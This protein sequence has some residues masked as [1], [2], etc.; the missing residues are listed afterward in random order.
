MPDKL[1]RPSRDI[2]TFSLYGELARRDTL[3]VVH[4]E[5][6]ETRSRV[7]D[8]HIE[9]HVHRGLYQVLF[10][11]GGDVTA[12]I[13][14]ASWRC[15]GPVALTIH[16]ALAHGF[17][18]SAGAHGYV[19]TVDQQ[20]LFTDAHKHDDL[21]S[22]L[23]VAPL[24]V[25]L[26]ATQGLCT[27]VEELLAQLLAE[28]QQAQDGAA[29]MREWLARAA[30]LLLVR[31]QAEQQAAVASNRGDFA[32]YT[33]FRAAV[34]QHYKE[35][36]QVARYAAELRIMPVRL[37]RVCLRIAGRTAFD[38]AQERLLAEACRQLAYLPSAIATIAY[39]LGFQ[40]PAYFSRLFKKRFGTTPRAY[41]AATPAASTLTAA[42]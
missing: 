13:G 19:L 34:E 29:L 41:R 1:S 16:P 30:L 32:L 40:D 7:H 27:R 17:D 33:R 12:G 10:L 22:P 8:W 31:A 35:Q 9:T 20:L 18:F 15:T 37:N 24:A 42:H 38:I 3:D 14:D 39:D 23:F 36:W 28:S 11:L 26:T 5:L 2:P 25:A 4:I 6:I 21:F